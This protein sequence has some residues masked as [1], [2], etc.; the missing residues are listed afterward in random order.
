MPRGG[1]HEALLLSARHLA[2]ERAA[3]LGLS[4]YVNPDMYINLWQ[5]K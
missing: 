3:Y 1:V 2:A 4:R 5:G